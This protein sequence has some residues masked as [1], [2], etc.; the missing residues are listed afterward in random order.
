MREIE[1]N[2][3]HLSSRNSMDVMGCRWAFVLEARGLGCPW[4][5]V[6][7]GTQKMKHDAYRIHAE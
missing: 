5:S 3:S 4:L 6:R 1:T 2:C 7:V